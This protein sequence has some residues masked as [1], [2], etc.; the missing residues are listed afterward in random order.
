M[1]RE[2]ISALAKEQPDSEVGLALG[3]WWTLHR[4]VETGERYDRNPQGR[5]IHDK[6]CY[7]WARLQRMQTSTALKA[8]K[9]L[10]GHGI[11]IDLD[12]L[13]CAKRLAHAP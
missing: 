11:T 13:P 8:L 2:Q 1:T 5:I 6:A 9:L 7:S 10:E 3:Y 12:S 4:F